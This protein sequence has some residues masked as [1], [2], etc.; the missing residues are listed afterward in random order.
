MKD[1][2]FKNVEKKTNINKDTIMSLAKKLQ[3]SNFKDEKVL[4][5]VIDELSSLTG[6][7][8]DDSKRDKIIKAIKND[9]VPSD[10]ENKW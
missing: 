1:S 3:S 7:N 2:L 10:I 4:N 9:K 6:K 8:I 5:E